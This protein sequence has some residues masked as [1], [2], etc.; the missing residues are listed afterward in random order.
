MEISQNDTVLNYLN[1]KG[2]TITTLE[3]MQRWG[4]MR[5]GARIYDL[6]RQGHKIKSETVEVYNR[7]GDK[8]RV[9]RYILLK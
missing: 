9:A 5:L 4:I 6:K 3:A 8:C 7:F 2:H 1:G